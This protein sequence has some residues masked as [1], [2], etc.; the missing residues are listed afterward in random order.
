[1]TLKQ[2]II[3]RTD[4]DMG[5]GKLCAQGAHAS[6]ESFLKALGSYSGGIVLI[7][8]D[9]IDGIQD[10][11]NFDKKEGV[12]DKQIIAMFPNEKKAVKKAFEM[13]K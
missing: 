10:I 7:R 6:I 1:M 13:F 2:V 4:L 12:T 11:T 5:K 8:E 3:L 9:Q